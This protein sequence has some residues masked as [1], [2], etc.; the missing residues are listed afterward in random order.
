MKTY[1]IA[2]RVLDAKFILN[3]KKSIEKNK[4]MY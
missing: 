3:D 2:I 1:L 4:D